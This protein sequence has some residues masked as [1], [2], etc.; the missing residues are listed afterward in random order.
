[1][2]VGIFAY[3]Q[4][5]YISA[6][7]SIAYTL[8]EELIKQ[9]YSIIHIGYMQDEKQRAVTSYGG[10]KIRFLNNK[11]K[12]IRKLENYS[13]KILGDKWR[14]RD[15]IA[16]LRQI[17][18]EEKIDMLICV[19][20][21]A[22]DLLV[23]HYANLEVPII[24]YQ[25]DP[26]Y[27]HM[28]QENPVKKAEFIKI[29]KGIKHLFTTDLLYSECTRDPQF[30]ALMDRI[31]FVRFPKLIR[32]DCPSRKLE[33]TVRLLYAGSF[34]HAIRSPKILV[35]LKKALPNHCEVV[36]CGGCDDAR[37]MD[38]LRSSGITCK[39]YCSQET[40]G[41]EMARA[42]V[43]INIGN[44]IKNQLGSKIVDYIGTGKPIINICQFESCPTI[45]VLEKYP[46]KLNLLDSHLD[47]D[48]STNLLETFLQEVVGK[49]A[50]WS[51]IEKFY[52]EYTPAYVANAF[53]EA[54]EE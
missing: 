34:Y 33:K 11:I 25:L 19:I 46:F 3:R 29:L 53:V 48:I 52:T 50:P 20:A 17:V 54:M 5:P 7:T 22:D 37:D 47:S 45:H 26:Y 14:L 9:G 35:A 24:L 8:G 49:K 39:G 36:F 38:L 18:R 43:L 27:N 16:G 42:D 28:D 44:L 41:E 2:R 32:T 13:A 1:M 12:Q 10:A 31:T 6:N 15:E 21:P 40:L 30:S 51:E 23:T 4:L